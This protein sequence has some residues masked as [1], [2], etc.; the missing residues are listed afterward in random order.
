MRCVAHII[1]LIVQDGLSQL[2]NIIEDIKESVRFIN[3]SE[4]RLKKFSKIIHH[5]SIPLRKINH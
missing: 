2:T 5:L 3:H 1:N 4:G